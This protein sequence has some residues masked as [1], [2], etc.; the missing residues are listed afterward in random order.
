V[1]DKAGGLRKTSSDL[2]SYTNFDIGLPPRHDE[3]IETYKKTLTNLNEVL[4]VSYESPDLA[5]PRPFH[6]QE[7]SSYFAR[8]NAFL[9]ELPTDTPFDR[10]RSSLQ[11]APEQI[12]RAERAKAVR[13]TVMSLP[14]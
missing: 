14:K 3:T 9:F 13:E 1:S 2:Q 6:Q 7:G 8:L 12:A 5:L 11:N 4:S 10:D